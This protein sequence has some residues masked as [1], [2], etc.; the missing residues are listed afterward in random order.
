MA[1]TVM[2][3]HNTDQRQAICVAHSWHRTILRCHI[4]LPAQ[5]EVTKPLGKPP[6]CLPTLK[7]MPSITTLRN[8]PTW[9]TVSCGLGPECLWSGLPTL[10]GVRRGVWCSWVALPG[11]T[12]HQQQGDDPDLQQPNSP[13]GLPTLA[14]HS[15]LGFAFTA[16]DVFQAE[17]QP[18][19]FFFFLWGG[20]DGDTGRGHD[21]HTTGG[22]R[23]EKRRQ[24]QLLRKRGAG[25]Y[26]GRVAFSHLHNCKKRGE[27]TKWE[28]FSLKETIFVGRGWNTVNTTVSPDRDEATGRRAA[29]GLTLPEGS[30][31]RRGPTISEEP[32]EQPPQ[33]PAQQAGRRHLAVASAAVTPASAGGKAGAAGAILMSVSPPPLLP[34][35]KEEDVGGC[36]SPAQHLFPGVVFL[37]FFRL[38]VCLF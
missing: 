33:A 24:G 29:P 12:R 34:E 17:K 13:S 35:G 8:E 22:W 26:C 9:R 38:F 14:T 10:P 28:S 11:G 30:G 27:R 4:T 20:G 37:I 5:S 2:N 21:T 15:Y 18:F 7:T 32:G 25:T 36:Y 31:R 23:R 3:K 6:L 16:W 1:H 19:C